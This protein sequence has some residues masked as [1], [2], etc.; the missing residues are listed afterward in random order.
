MTL[1]H[2]GVDDV[3]LVIGYY[4]DKIRQAIG[5][6]SDFALRVRYVVQDQIGSAERALALGVQATTTDH[7]Y[8][9]CAD[10]LVEDSNVAMLR[11]I[12]GENAVFLT[13][14][15]QGSALPRVG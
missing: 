11:P 1:K 4:G 6:G 3:V 10:D 14:S 2:S 5:D 8:C 15:V 12:A 7:A 9:F 13:R